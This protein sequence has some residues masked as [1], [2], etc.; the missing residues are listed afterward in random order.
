MALMIPVFIASPG[1]VKAERRIVARAVENLS[2]RLVPLYGVGLVTVKWEDFAPQAP[3][4]A[5]TSF[6]DRILQRIV[7][8]SLFMG[9]LYRR[10]GTPVRVGS[11]TTGT[12]AEFDYAIK[13]RDSITMLTYFRTEGSGDQQLAVGEL[14][15]K[16][17]QQEL[18][19]Q[20][21]R[22]ANPHELERRVVSWSVRTA[23]MQR[24]C[25]RVLR[26]AREKTSLRQVLSIWL[27]RASLAPPSSGTLIVNPSM[28]SAEA[29]P[30][31][32]PEPR[33]SDWLQR[34]CPS[35]VFEDFKAIQKVEAVLRCIRLYGYQ[36]VDTS[37]PTANVGEGN[38]VWL[39]F[40]RNG[41][42][43]RRLGR[44]GRRVKFSFVK[45]PSRANEF[46]PRVLR[47]KKGSST[48]NII[49]PELCTGSA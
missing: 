44:L 20:E 34:F 36:T 40:P 13:N 8:H 7:P 6:Q 11:A 27:F 47:W 2:R 9:I 14:K 1:D 18:H 23:I 32:S 21:S 45:S 35:V 5:S 26:E 48:L 39:C 16:L 38:R 46:G 25:F 12:E 28:S 10:Y 4:D 15:R 43:K 19:P 29:L 3:R 42:A 33:S 17:M 37:F 30:S 24:R 49:S 31:G 22:S 41:P